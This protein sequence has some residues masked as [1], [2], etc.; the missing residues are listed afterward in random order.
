[1]TQLRCAGG[2]PREARHRQLHH[3]LLRDGVAGIGR[4]IG[5]AVAHR[6]QR[7]A[8]ARLVA[9]QMI[10]SAVVRDAE[11][12]GAER[13]HLVH[14]RQQV[15]GAG[16]GLLHDVLAVRHRAGHA[17][18]VAVQLRPQIGH[19]L[20]ETAAALMLNR[21]EGIGRRSIRHAQ[22][23]SATMPWS[24]LMPNAGVSS[25]FG[26][27]RMLT[28]CSPKSCAY[29]KPRLGLR[30][31]SRIWI[32]H[33]LYSACFQFRLILDHSLLSVLKPI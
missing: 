8:H 13:R 26:S 14:L 3:L 31:G 28:T 20:E 4:R 23:P 17:R 29:G 30:L 11:Q 12:P 24:P 15:I 5:G 21:E 19:Q 25:Y 16:Q 32:I 18:T 6:V 1:M 9:P 10:Q 22:V 7:L 27:V 2:R 33:E